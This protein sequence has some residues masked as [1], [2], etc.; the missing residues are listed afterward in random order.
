MRH[1]YGFDPKCLLW[2]Y[3]PVSKLIFAVLPVLI[4]VFIMIAGNGL[5]NTL[6]PYRATVEGFSPAMVGV[7][8]SAYF[9]G[10]LAGTWTAPSIVRRVGHIRAFAAYSAIVSVAVLAFPLAV[11][12]FPWVLL[13]ALVGF[14][15]A[16]L[17]AVVEGWISAKAG[18]SHRGRMLG[19]YNIANFTGSM[20]GQQTLRLFEPKSFALFS[21]AASFLTLALVPMAMTRAEPPPIP[22]KGRLVIRELLK[23]SLISVATSV[24][25]G[26][27][28]GTFWSIIP[29]YV[30]RL[31]LGPGTVASFMTWAILGSA[32]IPWPVGRLSDK[33][34]RRLVIGGLSFAIMVVEIALW[35]I[36]KPSPALLY[37]LGFFAGAF[38]T[39]IYPVVVSLSVDRLGP[40]KAVPVSST[41]LF[42]YCTGAIIGPAFVATLMTNYGDRIM[43]AHNTLMHLAMIGFVAWGI[44]REGPAENHV[45]M[46]ID[47]PDAPLN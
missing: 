26:L 45:K 27:A 40:D 9:I 22:G 39:S 10:M 36:A 32:L 11:S 4:A 6:I 33:F 31:N 14:C 8:G 47:P 15:F 7:I 44:W 25:L 3:S 23:A 41:T 42:L 38:I 13:R 12:P 21:A 43:F 18:S 19:I 30:Q 46:T 1:C 16:G 5:I 29:A 17:Y 35:L 2:L 28:N 34:D 20:A 24:L 37:T